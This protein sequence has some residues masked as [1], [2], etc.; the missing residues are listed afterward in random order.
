MKKTNRYLR[1]KKW[2]VVLLM[3]FMIPITALS[4]QQRTS[5]NFND[6]TLKE[7]VQQIANQHKLTVAYS[8][9]FIDLDKKLSLNV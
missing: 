2:C 3:C 1:T 4:Q 7:A 6:L 8:K 9:E 5:V